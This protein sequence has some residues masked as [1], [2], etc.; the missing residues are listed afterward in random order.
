MGPVIAVEG[1]SVQFPTGFRKPPFQAVD[2]LDLEV[3]AGEIIGVL[4]PNGSGKTT[5]L[6]VLSGLLRPTSGAAHI[7][8]LDPCDRSLVTRVGYQPEGQ[9]PLT[10]LSA[11]QFLAYLCDLMRLPPATARPASQQW[12]A[13]LGLQD[14]GRKAIHH[15]STGMRRRLAL[16]AALVADPE[17]LLL[18]EPTSGLDPEGSLLVMEILRERSAGGCAV[19]LAS[20]HLQEV[21]QMCDRVYLLQAGRVARSGSLDQLLGTGDT[22]LVLRGLDASG[23][24][25]VVAAA[26]RAGGEVLSQ[27]AER[28]HLFALFRAQE[29]R[30]DAD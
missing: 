26:E 18:D 25:E 10:N 5:L 12:L 17:V 6:R 29:R 20:H 15:F 1:L 19:L 28:E 7:L 27:S 16:A 14:T 21:E 23:L 30:S 3:A 2:G 24:A 13:R 11:A 22:R 8:G 4:G 9:L